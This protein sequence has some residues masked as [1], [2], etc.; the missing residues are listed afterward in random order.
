[1]MKMKMIKTTV[2]SAPAGSDKNP[3]TDISRPVF[4][5]DLQMHWYRL[6]DDILENNDTGWPVGILILSTPI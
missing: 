2:R 4:M 3:R 5:T 6:C 1:M